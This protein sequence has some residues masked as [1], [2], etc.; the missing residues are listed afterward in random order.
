MKK[1]TLVSQ[2][3][4]LDQHTADTQISEI[5]DGSHLRKWSRPRI[6]S[7]QLQK[8][9]KN[10]PSHSSRQTNISRDS[11]QESIVQDKGS[12]SEQTVTDQNLAH[13]DQSCDGDSE[14]TSN[15]KPQSDEE[16]ALA[17][18]EA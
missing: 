5:D 17:S 2:R 13:K 10:V 1:N 8:N 16:S 3:R 4:R 6:S 9:S 15:A 18:Q 14:V 12:D 7:K 11:H